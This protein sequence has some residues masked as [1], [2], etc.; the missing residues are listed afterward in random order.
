MLDNLQTNNK[1]RFVYS[2]QVYKKTTIFY[3]DCDTL[4]LFNNLILLQQITCCMKITY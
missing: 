3:I 4:S 2:M 1:L